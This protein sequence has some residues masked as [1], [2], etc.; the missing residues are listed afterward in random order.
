V[1]QIAF[2]KISLARATV[3]NRIYERQQLVER[4]IA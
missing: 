3:A 4:R 2:G 1:K